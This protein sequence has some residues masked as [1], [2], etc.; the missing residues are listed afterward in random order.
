MAENVSGRLAGKVALITGASAGIGAATARRFGDEGASLALV[1]R[2]AELLEQVAGELGDDT[3]CLLADVSDS[4]QVA[5]AVAS[6]VER[7]GEIDVVVNNAGNIYPATLAETDDETWR[8]QIEVNLGGSFY[9]A[10]EASEKIAA[11]GSIVN[12][13]SECSVIGMEMCVA[14]CAA[15]AGVIGL[16][17]SLAAALAPRVRVN[18]ICPGPIDTRMLA[19]EFDL[20]G[21]PDGAREETL[22]RVPLNRLG[23]AEEVAAGI[24]YLAAEAHYATGTT[25]ELDGGTTSV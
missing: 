10:R 20:T 21:D 18:A 6:T 4:A 25:L 19:G 17:R 16:T 12:V 7:F 9:V 22:Q 5:E 8:K 23:T 2:N 3:L 24:L 15:K 14:Y 11:G 1:A 13:G